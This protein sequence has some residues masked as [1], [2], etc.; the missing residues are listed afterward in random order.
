M[1]C[2][3]VGLQCYSDS[4]LLSPHLFLEI[5]LQ[6]LNYTEQSHSTFVPQVK[7]ESFFDPIFL[8]W[9]SVHE[10]SEIWIAYY[11]SFLWGPRKCSASSGKLFLK[12]SSLP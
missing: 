7:I 11:G 2:R 6:R 8:K 10:Q 4:V 1:G 12:N 9:S 3:V 5:D